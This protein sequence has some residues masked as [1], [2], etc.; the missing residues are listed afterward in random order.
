M[1]AD[2]VEIIRRGY[3]LFASGDVTAVAELFAPDA[4]IGDGGGLGIAGTVSGTR[5]GAEGYMA[6]VADALDAFDDYRNEVEEY[7][8]VGDA[9]V[10]SV[11]VRGRG[12][13]SGAP[14]DIHLAHLWT[15]RD[16]KVIRGEVYRSVE[17]A[18]EAAQRPR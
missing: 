15:L 10:A 17:E 4:E 8:D 14:L 3:E 12:K 1:S 7:I 9:V 11:R 16:G 18:L 13:A 5:R 6:S 2:N